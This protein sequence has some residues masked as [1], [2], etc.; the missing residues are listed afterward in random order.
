MGGRQGEEIIVAK[1]IIF[2]NSSQS[3]RLQCHNCHS[4]LLRAC[5]IN[6]MWHPLES[7]R[8]VRCMAS[9]EHPALEKLVRLVKSHLKRAAGL[10]SSRSTL[11]KACVIISCL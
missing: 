1:I 11:D 8:E 4:S 7:Q 2:G 3:S 10:D 5:K 9:P 6:E